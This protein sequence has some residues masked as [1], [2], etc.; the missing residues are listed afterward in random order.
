MEEG[1][2]TWWCEFEGMGVDGDVGVGVGEG[3][4]VEIDVDVGDVPREG[5]LDGLLDGRRRRLK[6]QRHFTCNDH[7]DLAT[8]YRLACTVRSSVLLMDA[9]TWVFAGVLAIFSAPCHPLL[10]R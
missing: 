7:I 3:A 1:P 10:K 4:A 9:L 5:A 6:W 8:N 2:I